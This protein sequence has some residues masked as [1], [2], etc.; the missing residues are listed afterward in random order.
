MMSF[1]Q[2]KNII[3]RP[4]VELWFLLSSEIQ[5]YHHNLVDW[6]YENVRIQTINLWERIFKPENESS[7]GSLRIGL[8]GF[9]QNKSVFEQVG[10]IIASFLV[11]QGEAE[12]IFDYKKVR[13]LPRV[14]L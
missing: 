11:G 14:G 7:P 8:L 6:V 1:E 10:K 12:V 9:N 3:K 2:S 4:C 5:A 13:N